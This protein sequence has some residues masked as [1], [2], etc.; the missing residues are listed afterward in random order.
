VWALK[1]QYPTSLEVEEIGGGSEERYPTGC[2]LR[3]DFPARGDMPPVKLYWYDGKRKGLKSA[4]KG[5]GDDNVA[6]GSQNLPPL[7]LELEKKYGKAGYAGFGQ[8]NGTIYVGEQ[9]MM[10]TGTYGSPFRVVPEEAHKAIK[11]PA[12]TIARVKGSHHDDYFNGIRNGTLPSSNFEVAAVLAE[13]VVLGCL[14]TRAG[15]GKKLEYDGPNLK[16]TNAPEFTKF[17]SR[18]NRKGWEA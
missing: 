8:G 14:V 15:I 16:F 12:K 7:H 18:E 10:F 9:G 11:T 4:E 1:L 5:D 17:L 6:K 3:Y 2:R 13:V